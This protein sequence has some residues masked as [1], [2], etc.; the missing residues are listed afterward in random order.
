MEAVAP[1]AFGMFNDPGQAGVPYDGGYLATPVG[2]SEMLLALPFEGHDDL[3]DDVAES[4]VNTEWVRAAGGHWAGAHDH[5]ERILAA[6]TR[7]MPCSIK[8][9]NVDD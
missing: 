6:E 2:S 8:K 9:P 5:N 7:G 1:A 3:F 4:F